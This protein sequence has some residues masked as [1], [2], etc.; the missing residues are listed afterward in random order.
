MLRGGTFVCNKQL[1]GKTMSFNVKRLKK[2]I[3]ALLAAVMLC[4]LTGCANEEGSVRTGDEIDTS[5]SSEESDAQ[6]QTESEADFDL[7]DAVKSITVF[8]RE[9]SLPC[10]IGDFGEDFS[11]KEENMAT[12]GGF[13][14]CGLLYQ[15]KTIGTATF[16]DTDDLDS[17]QISG[18]IMG[19]IATDHGV[20]DELREL[21]YEKR[22]RYSDP[23]E[24]EIA[25]LS[26]DSDISD[27]EKLFGAPE[28]TE[29]DSV[30][31]KAETDAVY[32]KVE[33]YCGKVNYIWVSLK[34][35]T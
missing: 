32:L 5:R 4:G 33:F 31:Y 1:K 6:S 13:T 17:A 12:V 23:I 21:L 34:G 22:G 19:F 15:G 16:E 10:T 7:D 3:S 30:E 26:F 9:V 35:E 8:G 11:L 24:A 25:G 2:P 29:D 27:A 18:L 28:N 20:T 14:S